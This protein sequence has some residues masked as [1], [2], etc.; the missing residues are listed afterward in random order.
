MT[1]GCPWGDHAC[2]PHCPVRQARPVA[3]TPATWQLG[4]SPFGFGLRFLSS[5]SRELAELAASTR[6][7]QRV[8]AALRQRHAKTAREL[9]Q[10]D[11]GAHL[12]ARVGRGGHAWDG[13]TGLHVH[14]ESL[15]AGP[16]HACLPPYWCRTGLAPLHSRCITVTLPL[17]YR[18]VT[19]TLPYRSRIL[20]GL[21]PDAPAVAWAQ[22]RLGE[23]KQ[24]VQVVSTSSK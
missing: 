1:M 13:R 24:Q 10:R 9:E 2:N 8:M 19:V 14:V 4:R 16:G 7:E 21:R 20:G 22:G 3:P 12:G 23:E 17:R 11:R 18:Y 15:V 5:I 6:L